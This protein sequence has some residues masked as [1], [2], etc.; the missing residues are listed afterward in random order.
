MD[1]PGVQCSDDRRRFQ[2]RA[3]QGLNGIDFVEVAT[4]EK[5]ETLLEVYLLGPLPP[6]Q[7]GKPAV[8]FRKENIQ[9]EGGVQIKPQAV[10]FKP[11]GNRGRDDI[12]VITIDK[13][14]DSSVYTLR[15]EPTQASPLTYVDPRYRTAQFSFVPDKP[16][17]IDCVQTSAC[18]APP[19]DTPDLNYL[20]KDYSSFRQLLLDRLAT[21]LPG[22][23][24]RRSPDLFLTLVE[25]L[26]YEADQ[27]S[28]AQDAVGTEAY[29]DT[30][31][32][33]T[34]IRRHA[35]LVD[36]PMHEGCNARA[37]VCLEVKGNPQ[38]DARALA[39]I[40]WPEGIRGAGALV[41]PD[42]L[43]LVSPANYKTFELLP[44][45]DEPSVREQDIRRPEELARRICADGGQLM[46]HIRSH[47]TQ[48]QLK[49]LGRE[50][51]GP[52]DLPEVIAALTALLNELTGDPGMVPLEP[53]A[54]Q[55]AI[56]RYGTLNALRGPRLRQHN[57][58]TIE[59]KFPQE[60]APP[61]SLH[62]HAA[63]NAIRFYTWGSA[64]C[65]LPAGS[66]SATLLDAWSGGKPTVRDMRSLRAG[67][68][69]VL[70][71]VTSPLTGSSADADAAH[72]HAVRLTRVQPDF[73]RLTD[74]P[75]VEV[76]WDAADALPFPLVLS[77][78]GPA[79]ECALLSDLAVARGNVVLVDHG[80][81]VREPEPARMRGDRRIFTAVPFAP[82]H[83]TVP[84]GETELCCAGE[85]QPANVHGE[86][87]S[88]EPVL[89]R[90]PLVFSQP[91]PAGSSAN[92]ALLQDPAA[93]LPQVALFAPVTR[94]HP[95]LDLFER[96]PDTAMA[97]PAPLPYERWLPRQDLLSSDRD[98]L[99]FVVEVDDD[100]GAHLR[101]GDD[102]LGTRPAP[103][104]RF[105][106][107]YRTGGGSAGNVGGEA[108]SHVVLRGEIRDGTIISVRNP[109]PAQGGTDR[110]P[111]D[112]VR[113]KAPHVFKSRLERAITADDYAAI[114]LRDFGD[115]V[116]RA[117]AA[118]TPEATGS[119]QTLVSVSIDPMGSTADDPTLR[120]LVKEHLDMYRRIGHKVKVV[121]KV[122]Y[123]F[124]ELNLSVGFHAHHR[125]GAVLGALLERFSNRTM[126]D[127]TRGFFH[128]DELTFGQG[129]AVSAVTAA[130][131]GVPG[132]AWAKVTRLAPTGSNDPLPEKGFLKL[133][134]DEIARLDNDP[135]FAANGSLTIDLKVA[136]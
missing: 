121:E 48:E 31:R 4:G 95:R 42:A 71:E 96:L 133:E 50:D 44:S 81:T 53:E 94:P 101:F 40:T 14:G 32:L 3:S 99:H 127:G 7:Q 110:E 49:L 129:I 132:V 104:T 93:A 26:A 39:F 89:A 98:D 24:E 25:I 72:R 74:T 120:Q 10:T 79:P 52:E 66:T 76:S 135:D 116:Q 103:D 130:A 88:Y 54:V 18:P 20:A 134:P 64:E 6:K 113:L 55:A 83:A 62:F 28:Y 30:A 109:M 15:L 21:T 122:S 57:R 126:A 119:G 11:E 38:V 12:A 23:Q 105:L 70:E 69:L 91:L 87:V 47:L 27:L 125:K 59:Q 36:Y 8:L 2:V 102:A 128:P 124:L 60:V 97:R 106:A 92:Q 85:G 9:I 131:H 61:D 114:V 37:W 46:D 41:L 78:V 90:A 123:V 1:G 108:I 136:V 45:E 107:W 13:P 82:P 111:V 65:C 100:G 86:P 63:H 67:D 68:I 29:L 16:L 115:R 17:K 51:K 75:V 22:W 43:R 117:A 80:E 35:R 5:S 84:A 58:H 73:D 34:S 118:M 56:V 112:Q 19:G 77:A 33:R